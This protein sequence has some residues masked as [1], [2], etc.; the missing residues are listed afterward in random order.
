[1]MDSPYI[2]RCVITKKNSNFESK[3]CTDFLNVCI[4]VRLFFIAGKFNPYIKRTSP[5]MAESGSSPPEGGQ[6]TLHMHMKK[7]KSDIFLG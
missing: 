5:T 6:G 1:M 2:W 4:H 7:G 3:I